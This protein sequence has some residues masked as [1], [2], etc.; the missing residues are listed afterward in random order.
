MNTLQERLRN[1]LD[2]LTRLR[3]EVAD[4]HAALKQ[5]REALERYRSTPAT[6]AIEAIDKVQP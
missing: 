5:A 1:H 2:E 6:R 4:L 3:T